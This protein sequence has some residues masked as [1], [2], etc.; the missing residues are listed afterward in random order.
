LCRGPHFCDHRQIGDAFKLTKIAG[1]YWRGDSKNAQLQRI[2]APPGATA[3]T[4]RYLTRLEKRKTRPPAH[5]QGDGIF[6]FSP[7]R[8]AGLPLW[9]R[10]HGDPQELNSWRCR[11]AQGR[12]CPRGDA[13]LTKETLVSCA[14]AHLPYYADTM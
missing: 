14:P 3:R 4:R 12:L 11:K 2:Y 10:T 13:A 1:A 5:R 6:T 8:R 9:M 7:E